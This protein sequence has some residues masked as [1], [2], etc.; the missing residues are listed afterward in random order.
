M[1]RARMQD[2][3]AGKRGQDQGGKH[4]GNVFTHAG[5]D[6]SGTMGTGAFYNPAVSKACPNPSTWPSP[7]LIANSSIW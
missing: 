3:V 1:N 6:G 5:P 7:S 4:Y 2:H